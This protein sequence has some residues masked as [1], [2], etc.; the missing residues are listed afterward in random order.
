MMFVR[1]ISL[2]GDELVAQLMASEVELAKQ[3]YTETKVYAL[4]A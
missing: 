1:E 3:C 4:P 2:E